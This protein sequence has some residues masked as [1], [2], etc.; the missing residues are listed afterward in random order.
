[1]S[2][3]DHTPI[4]EL[5]AV[6]A[7]GGLEDAEGRELD[8][9]RTEHGPCEECGELDRAFAQT[10]GRLALSLDPLPVD[11]GIAE[12]ILAEGGRVAVIP[13]MGPA[14]VPEPPAW[15]PDPGRYRGNRVRN[16]RFAMAVGIAAVLGLVIVAMLSYLPGLGRVSTHPVAAERF[17]RLVAPQGTAPNAELTIAYT[18]GSSGVVVWG[19]NLPDP[20]AGKVYEVWMI[21][22]AEPVSGGCLQP[23]DGQVAAYLDANLGTTSQMAVT[24]EPSA[25][26]SAPT[27]PPAFSAT[28][29]A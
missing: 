23:K 29:T 9:L 19:S 7:L 21:S 27:S 16:R 20:G 5:M 1:M 22:G 25:C 6:E 2:A 11:M 17:V 18:P 24:A 15:E 13:D 3:R 12:A 8:R 26:P 4:Q 10:A 28:L 14:P